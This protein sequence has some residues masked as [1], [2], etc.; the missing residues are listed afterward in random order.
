M[1]EGL[2]GRGQFDAVVVRTDYADERAWR[3]WVATLPQHVH[4]VDDPSWSG[5]SIDD[6][7]EVTRGVGYVR[8]VGQ[9]I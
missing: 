4:L 9:R 1:S 5:T 6:V 8:V 3:A 7:R 2:V